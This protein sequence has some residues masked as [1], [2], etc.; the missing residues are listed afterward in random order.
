MFTG[1]KTSYSTILRTNLLKFR[2]SGFLINRTNTYPLNTR[3][4]PA[5]L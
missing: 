1:F 2:N 4:A 5:I 3:N